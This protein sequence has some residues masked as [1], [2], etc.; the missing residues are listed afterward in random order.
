MMTFLLIL[1]LVLFFVFVV[2]ISCLQDEINK[3][4]E[5]NLLLKGTTFGLKVPPSYVF[6][7]KMDNFKEMLELRRPVW[8]RLNALADYL[9]VEFE[10]EPAK[11]ES[12]R[13]IKK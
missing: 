1:V 6:R 10:V 5:D 13:V 11:P 3:L 7:D 2:R 9:K 12:L 4:K 8:E